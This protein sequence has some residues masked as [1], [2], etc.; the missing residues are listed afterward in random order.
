MAS[1]HKGKLGFD[2]SSV[3]S[4]TKKK[5]AQQKEAFAE[6]MKKNQAKRV[7]VQEKREKKERKA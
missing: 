5:N 6:K 2:H 3:E 1:E 7:E 4:K